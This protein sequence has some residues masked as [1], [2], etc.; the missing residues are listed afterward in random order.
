MGMVFIYYLIF[1]FLVLLFAIIVFAVLR[2]HGLK[3]LAV[4]VFAVLMFIFVN[5]AFCDNIDEFFYFKSDAKEDL[6]L[7]HLYLK[8]D[9]E[10]IDNE[11]IGFPERY[12]KTKLKISEND[13]NRIIAEIK[14]SKYFVESKD[15]RA[16]YYKMI[17][18]NSKKIMSNYIHNS[19]YFREVY[20]NTEGYVGLSANAILTKE[21]NIIEYNNIED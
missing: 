4:I 19:R 2:S 6:K 10:I 3:K 7:V 21:T 5:L 18:K 1:I 16:L 13:K 11:V 8:D 12:Q 15:C 14:S 9:F 20:S 17:G